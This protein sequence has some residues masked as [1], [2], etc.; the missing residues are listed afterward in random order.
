MLPDPNHSA[1]KNCLLGSCKGAR[2]PS[3]KTQTWTP[4]GNL[5]GSLVNRYDRPTPRHS[6]DAGR[7]I[8]HHLVLYPALYNSFFATGLFQCGSRRANGVTA[9]GPWI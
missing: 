2:M 4:E 7:K 5:G 8:A 9:G 6:D 1:G 3:G